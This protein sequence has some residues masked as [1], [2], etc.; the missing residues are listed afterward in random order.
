MLAESRE[1]GKDVGRRGGRALVSL[2]PLEP[3]LL[4]LLL[5][6]PDGGSLGGVEDLRHGTHEILGVV[7]EHFT[8]LAICFIWEGRGRGRKGVPIEWV[9][10][11]SNG[12]S[13][14]KL[15]PP[16]STIPILK[17]SPFK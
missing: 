10:R 1:E 15:L 6:N 12:V 4:P 16:H 7:C 8:R 3:Q 14:V 11:Y 9:D 13:M 2:H 5:G 17:C